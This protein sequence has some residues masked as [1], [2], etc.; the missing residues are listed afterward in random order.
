ML[1]IYP[2]NFHQE[3]SYEIHMF[4]KPSLHF[5]AALMKHYEEEAAKQIKYLLFSLHNLP[6]QSDKDPLPL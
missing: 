2:L 6:D 1:N 5:A 3:N 4:Q